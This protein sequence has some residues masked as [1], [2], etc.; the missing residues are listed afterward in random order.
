M[1]RSIKE[2][3]K[4]ASKLRLRILDMVIK[5]NGGHIGG[6]FSVIDIINNIDVA[7]K[8]IIGYN[9]SVC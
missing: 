2:L 4:I 7:I 1:T 5:A 3:E 6:A 9:D 8:F